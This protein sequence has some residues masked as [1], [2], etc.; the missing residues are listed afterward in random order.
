MA[1][2]AGEVSAPTLFEVTLTCP[3]SEYRVGEIPEIRVLVRNRSD[4]SLLLPGVLDGSEAG[5]RY[6]HYIPRIGGA[7]RD[8]TP[9]EA[10]DFVAPLRRG[11]FVRLASGDAFDPTDRA[12]GGAFFPIATFQRLTRAPG[13][14]AVSLRLSTESRSFEEWLGNLPSKPEPGIADLI[15]DVPR[16]TVESNVLSLSVA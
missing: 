2:H 8:V 4:R 10:P 5:V 11:D 6:P 7:A 3:R 16:L 9:I 13:R 15:A 12:S 1:S 14:L